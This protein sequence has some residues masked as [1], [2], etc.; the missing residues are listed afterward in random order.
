MGWDSTT[1][2]SLET[3]FSASVSVAALSAVGAEAAGSR[4]VAPS[5]E[6]ELSAAMGLT[7]SGVGSAAM[8]G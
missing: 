3:G 7:V 6:V 4:A 2:S 8:V 1:A 5:G